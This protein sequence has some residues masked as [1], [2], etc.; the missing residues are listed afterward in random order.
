M[1]KIVEL[2]DMSRN[3]EIDKKNWSSQNFI[4]EKCGLLKERR[5]EYSKAKQRKVILKYL[6]II[7]NDWTAAY[8]FYEWV[9]W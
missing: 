3:T 1:I 7:K 4:E 2:G 5:A 8:L 9:S 6:K